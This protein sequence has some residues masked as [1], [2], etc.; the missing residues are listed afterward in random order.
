[1]LNIIKEAGKEI[2]GIAFKATVN[3]GAAK[4]MESYAVLN[5]IIGVASVATTAAKDCGRIAK[6]RIEYATRDPYWRRIEE[7]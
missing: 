1:M 7:L 6:Y 5:G 3:Y 4:I 2:G